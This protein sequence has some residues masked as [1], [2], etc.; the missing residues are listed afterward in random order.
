VSFNSAQKVAIRRY[1]GFPL[2]YYQYNTPFESLMDKI[3]SVAE[4][5]AAVETILAELVTVDAAIA[6]SGSTTS[7]AGGLR[8]VDEIEFFDVTTTSVESAVAAPERGRMLVN[9]LAACFGLS[10]GDLP[11]NYF[12]QGSSGGNEMLLG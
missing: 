9:R 8:K 5:Q 12:A 3:G 6:A 11:S 10:T 7:A 2:G 1:L 4:E